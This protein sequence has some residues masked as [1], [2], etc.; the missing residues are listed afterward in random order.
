[1]GNLATKLNMAMVSTSNLGKDIKQHGSFIPGKN[2]LK[3][4]ERKEKKELK[5]KVENRK[6]NKIN[7]RKTIMII[8]KIINEITCKIWRT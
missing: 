3:M 1:M 6:D 4:V 8:R 5:I 2:T 7:R